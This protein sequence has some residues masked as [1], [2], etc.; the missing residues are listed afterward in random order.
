MIRKWMAMALLLA[1]TAAL[2]GCQSL[3]DCMQALGGGCH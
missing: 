1:C 2:A 3:W